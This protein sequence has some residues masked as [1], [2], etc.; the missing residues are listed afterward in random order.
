MAPHPALGNPMGIVPA[1][2]SVDDSQSVGNI[3]KR[4]A[5][6]ERYKGWGMQDFMLIS[7]RS[8]ISPAGWMGFMSDEMG[9]GRS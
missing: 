4:T 6:S 5:R 2:G 8:E 9:D 1:D 3:V 7:Y